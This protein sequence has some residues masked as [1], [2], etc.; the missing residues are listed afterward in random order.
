MKI[1]AIVTWVPRAGS[2]AYAMTILL[3]S[4]ASTA[5]MSFSR[6]ISS[7]NPDDSGQT[8]TT[9]A[10]YAPLSGVPFFHV[11]RMQKAEKIMGCM[12]D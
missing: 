8:T 11:L 1:A 5:W 2:E 4:S 6:S 7:C 12:H 3:E 9:Y 10:V